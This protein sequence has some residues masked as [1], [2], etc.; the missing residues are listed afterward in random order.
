MNDG[1]IDITFY[2]SPFLDKPYDMS[3][4]EV[5]VNIIALIVKDMR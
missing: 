5:E 1:M 4:C 2:V 3:R